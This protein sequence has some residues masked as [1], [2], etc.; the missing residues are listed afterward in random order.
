M[1]AGNDDKLKPPRAFRIPLWDEYGQAQRFAG[2]VGLLSLAGGVLRV[3]LGEALIGAACLAFGAGLLALCIAS[4]RGAS[5][6]TLGLGAPALMNG[7]ACV[8]LILTGGRS[9]A[10]AALLAGAPAVAALW[11]SS[12]A[13]WL[14]LIAACAVAGLVLR[15]VSPDAFPGNQPWLQVDHAAWLVAPSAAALLMLAR[16][17]KHSHTEWREEVVAAHAVLAASE[18]RFRTYVENAHDVTAELGPT[19][20]LLFVSAGQ[21]SRFAAPIATMLGTKGG[22]YIHREDYAAALACFRAAASGRPST[23]IPLRYRSPNGSW[24]WLRVAVSAYRTAAG[25]QR[26]V[27]QA[28][29]S[30]AEQALA[31]AREA[32]I[33]EL[34]EQLAK[35]EA[36]LSPTPGGPEPQ[37][38]TGPERAR[39]RA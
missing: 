29:D 4:D 25:E 28:R 17:W 20:E 7:A 16:A 2:I 33:A 26:F 11:G 31:A 24:R 6:R 15:F 10:A 38:P 39:S 27:V 1:T 5:A 22:E 32:R 30:T 36:L 21:E 12:R 18:A 19:G 34:E 8:L 23:S 35:A 9:F 37:P 3:S 13:G 14:F